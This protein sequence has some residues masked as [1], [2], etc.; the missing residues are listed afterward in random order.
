M[1]RYLAYTSPARGHLYPLVDTLLELRRRGHD[2][3]V[4][5]LAAE[6]PALSELGLHVDSIDP[7]IEAITLDTWR[8]TTP[9][10][11]LG[12]ALTTF[13][14][15]GA[16]EVADLRGAMEAVQPDGVI[17]DITTTGAAAA[18]EESGVPWARTIPLFQQSWLWPG[19]PVGLL[20]VPFALEPDGIEVLNGPRRQV[21]LKAI[22][23]PGEAWTAPLHVYFTAPPLAPDGVEYPP[24]FRLVG[25]GLWEP[26]G[27]AAEWLTALQRPL[28][29]VSVSSEYQ[30]DGALIETALDALA[31]EDVEV[32]VTTGAHSPA[33]FRAPANARVVP[34]AAHG[35]L[36]RRAACVLCHGGMGVTQKTLAAGVPVCVVPFGR[37]QFDVAHRV[38]ALQAGTS[39]STAE[40]SPERL[41]AAVREARQLRPGAEQV[42]AAFARAGG[43]SAAAD[44]LET[45]LV[46]PQLPAEPAA[47]S[48]HS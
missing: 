20:M 46:R 5:T 29:V 4:R 30:A 22:S 47:T 45:L 48:S 11:G 39:M 37:D 31:D 43:A 25:P 1:A 36:V 40:L 24:S 13:A 28:V 14:A 35:P 41:R 38:T 8:A 3:Y 12:Q 6:V 34:W 2:V 42:S 16:H 23:H 44:A 27:D 32:V 9:Q 17:V 7:A 26:P 33:G 19:A 21:G 15:R 18:A 10:E